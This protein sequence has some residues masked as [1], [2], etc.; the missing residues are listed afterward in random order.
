MR[1]E[2]IVRGGIYFFRFF[3]SLDF[4]FLV[5][6]SPC[7]VAKILK[8]LSLMPRHFSSRRGMVSVGKIAEGLGLGNQYIDEMIG[9]NFEY[10]CL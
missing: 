3:S 5:P 6:W 2:I 4:F 1:Q 8:I 9:L 10:Q 7:N